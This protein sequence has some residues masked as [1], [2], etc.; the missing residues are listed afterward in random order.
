MMSSYCRGLGKIAMLILFN[1][2]LW[3]CA[4]S[5]MFLSIFSG[6]GYNQLVSNSSIAINTPLESIGNAFL[7]LL[8]KGS[9]HTLLVLIT[10]SFIGGNAL[11]LHRELGDMVIRLTRW[12]RR[13]T[14]QKE[15]RSDEDL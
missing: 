14:N 5:L 1:G 6:A 7:I 13:A 3:L 10:I 15:Y 12:W 11:I 9:I 8:V 4:I 2:F